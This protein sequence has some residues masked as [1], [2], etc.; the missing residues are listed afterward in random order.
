M[1]RQR[2]TGGEPEPAPAPR[3]V[4]RAGPAALVVLSLALCGAASLYGLRPPAA[5]GP[6]APPTEFAAGRAM[7]HLRAVASAPRPAGSA[8]HARTRDYLVEQLRR[9]G[10][11]PQ[12]QAD[13]KTANV[14]ARL[15]GTGDGRA[16]MLAGHYDTTPRSPGAADDGLAVASLL[17]TVRALKAGPPAR[18]DVVVLFTD[19]EELGLLG[20]NSFVY[21]HPWRGD[22]KVALN[23]DARG[24]S[25]PVLMFE[26]SPEN[27]WLVEQFAAAAPRPVANSVFYELYRRLPN[28]T[29]FTVFKN[30]GMSGLNFAP[31]GGFDA[32]HSPRDVADRVS[33]RTLQHM[34]GQA[35]ALAR[36][37]GDAPL[38]DVR[39]RDAVYFDLL[40][41]TLVSYPGWLALPLALL[42]VCLYA[43]ALAYGLRRRRLRLVH[44]GLGF[45]AQLAVLVGAAVMMVNASAVIGARAGEGGDA[46]NPDSPRGQLYALGLLALTLAVGSGVYAWFRRHVGAEGLLLGASLWWVLLLVL[47]AWFWPGGSYLFTWPLVGALLGA[48]ALL[49]AGEGGGASL[50]RAAVFA[51]CAAPGVLL[52][53]PL[54]YLL[55]VGLT[56]KMAA[57]V[58]LLPALLCGLLAPHF[59]LAAT[60]VGRWTFPAASALAALAL[61]FAA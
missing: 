22:V 23:F 27:G 3:I 24:N 47:T 60:A 18:N 51:A 38:D 49:A 56:M 20:A 5:L 28:D 45:L 1:S 29:D 61:F 37:L 16:V 7:E 9:L 59:E 48:W 58:V 12:V 44:L 33:Q 39:E 10:L 32:Y 6:D 35:L 15:K 50:G 41:L 19:A 4:G 31:I 8:E 11:D 21:G 46:F 30:G 2:T 13:A 55:L 40:A 36:R 25:G 14:L 43:G 54:T 42:C 53:L 26:T 34:G 52:V 57:T 17:E